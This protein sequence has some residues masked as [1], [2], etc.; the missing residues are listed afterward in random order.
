LGPVRGFYFARRVVRLIAELNPDIVFLTGDFYDGTAVDE[1]RMASAWKGF[2]PRHGV[3]YVTGNHEE[4]SERTKYLDAIEGAGIRVLRNEKVMVDGLQIA[5]VLYGEGHERQA[6]REALLGM[7]LE[8]T[9]PAILLTHVPQYYDVA[10]ET[11]ISLKLS[12]HTHKGQVFPWT[13]LARRVH[14]KYVYGLNEFKRMLVYTTSGAGTWGPP[15]RLATRAEV[16]LI[17]FR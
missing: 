5:G 11:G 4:F 16:V 7:K 17:R 10:E 1:V 13:W 14:G 9:R 15:M 6:F 3:Y 2:A 8:P 12:G